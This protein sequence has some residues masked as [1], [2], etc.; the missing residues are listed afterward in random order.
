MDMKVVV[1][2]RAEKQNRGNHG[3]DHREMMGGDASLADEPS[4]QEQ[5]NRAGAIQAGVND[6]EDGVL[7]RDGHLF[8]ELI[9]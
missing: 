5:Q 4:A 6:R 8:W 7:R 2:V 3:R 1:E 9:S